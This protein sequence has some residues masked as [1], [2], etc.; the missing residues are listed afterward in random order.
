MANVHPSSFNAP[1]K[2][3]AD[4]T[5]WRTTSPLHATNLPVSPYTTIGDALN[6][7]GDSP[8]LHRPH[9]VRSHSTTPCSPP[10]S[11]RRSSTTV[12]NTPPARYHGQDDG[13]LASLMNMSMSL[14]G[15]VRSQ[16]VTGSFFECTTYTYHPS[17]GSENLSTV[18]RAAAPRPSHARAQSY[19]GHASAG[20]MAISRPA[21]R[22]I[23]FHS[24]GTGSR[25]HIREL[26]VPVRAALED[27]FTVEGEN[28][29]VLADIPEKE[30]KLKVLVRLR[31]TC[32]IL[33]FL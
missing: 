13:D 10:S 23:F 19:N 1:S 28:D 26:G 30:L 33:S 6:G 21:N 22:I 24:V 29:M 27:A 3:R 17:A 20:S 15:G 5:G 7:N 25:H 32:P 18:T 12:M 2:N 31:S 14:K 16:T 4:P 11:R 9:S 8:P